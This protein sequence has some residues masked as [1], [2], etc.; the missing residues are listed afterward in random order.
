[1]E[2]GRARSTGLGPPLGRDAPPARVR[3]RRPSWTSRAARQRTARPAEARA[4]AATSRRRSIVRGV[5]SPSSRAE[6]EFLR[7]ELHW[8][9][10]CSTN[11]I[12]HNTYLSTYL[13][14]H[15]R[16]LRPGLRY[17]RGAIGNNGSMRCRNSSATVHGGRSP[18]LTSST[19]DDHCPSSDRAAERGNLLILRS[20]QPVPLPF[21]NGGESPREGSA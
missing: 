2:P 1:M 8:M 20:E 7:E 16:R 18:R 11:K 17:R 13:P 5:A 15:G 19:T 9:P 21:R 4:V 6:P 12:P 3:S 14:T 10:V